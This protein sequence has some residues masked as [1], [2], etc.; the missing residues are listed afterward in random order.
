MGHWRPDQK[1]KKEKGLCEADFPI[2]KE[3]GSHVV[4]SFLYHLYKFPKIIYTG[5]V[6]SVSEPKFT[7]DGVKVVFT[8]EFPQAIG[9]WI[10]LLI[11]G[12]D[13]PKILLLPSRS[14]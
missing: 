3:G 14:G 5:W 9:A 10:F 6:I 8:Y 2:G 4:I 12:G 13:T 1:K 7:S 11:K